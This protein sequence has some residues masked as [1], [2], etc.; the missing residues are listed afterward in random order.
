M[1]PKDRFK[2]IPAVHL[3]LIKDD[4]MLFGLRQNTGYEDGKFHL[5]AGHSDGGETISKAMI[6]E[7]KEETGITIKPKDL[8]FAHIMH[9]LGDTHERLDFFFVCK[10]WQGTPKVCEPDKCAE[11]KWFSPKKLPKNIIPYVRFVLK[12]VNKKIL[13]SEYG[14]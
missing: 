1:L 11:L 10:K 9:R 6:R 13:Y 2:L 5:I 14:W 12:R 4:K 8:K 3:F 7:A